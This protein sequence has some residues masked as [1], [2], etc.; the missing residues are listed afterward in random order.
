MVHVDGITP[1]LAERLRTTVLTAVASREGGEGLARVEFV[2]D[3]PR[4]RLT[5]IV[6]GA[7]RA[8]AEVLRLL[9]AFV[10]GAR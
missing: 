9:D 1:A 10:E 2:H 5:V 7:A 8:T 6:V 3:A 4:A